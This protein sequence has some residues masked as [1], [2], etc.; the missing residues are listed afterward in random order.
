MTITAGELSSTGTVTITAEDNDRYAAAKS[1][2]VTGTVTGSTEVGAPAPQTLT[3][4]ND[5]AAPTVSLELSSSSISEDGGEATVT[6]TLS[7]AAGEPVTV[8]VFAEAVSP[9][10]AG[11]FELSANTALTIQAGQTS[12]TER[13]SVAAVNDETHA[14]DRTVTVTGTVT[15]GP[16]GLAAPAAQTLQITED[17]DTPTVTLKL[18]PA[19]ISENGGE[20]TVTA[21]LSGPSSENLT[22]TV[23]A[24]PE[25]PAVDGDLELTGTTLTI[26]AG[27]TE[28]TG[29]VTVTAKDND[30]DAPEKRVTIGGTV[31]QRRGRAGAPDADDHDD[32][33]TPTLTL[34]LDPASISENGGVSP[35]TASL[36]GLS[37]ADV[38]VTVATAV[39]RLRATSC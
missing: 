25:S 36:D 23:T 3:I 7:E 4:T 32:E 15:A 1:V 16:E 18:D 21:S 35:V 30:L 14:P 9:A 37:S 6:A 31:R 10:E 12:S 26:E 22:V 8:T 29:E 27:A 24:R 19:S 11:D 5:D 34:V 38:T 33:D 2:T 20:T 17:E 28:S 39:R 13:V